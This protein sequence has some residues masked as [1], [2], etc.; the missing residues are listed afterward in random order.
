[1]LKKFVHAR[2][3]CSWLCSEEPRRCGLAPHLERGAPGGVNPRGLHARSD[4]RNDDL[5]VFDLDQIHGRNA[6][7][8]FFAG[9][10]GLSELNFSVQPGDIELPKRSTNGFRIGLTGLLDGSSNSTDAII[11]AE[12]LS[13][14]GELEATLLPLGDKALGG[15]RIRR[16]FRH[17]RCERGEVQGPVNCGAGLIDQLIRILR[18]DGGD[19]LL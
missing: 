19:P 17:P 4:F 13:D 8:A 7:T 9:G 11:T 12:A 5:A 14:T 6:L 2:L 3:V 18:A 10:S 15:L 1:M 16:R